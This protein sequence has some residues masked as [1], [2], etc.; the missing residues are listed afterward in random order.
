MQVSLCS[1]GYSTLA[2]TPSEAGSKAFVSRNDLC[3]ACW[4]LHGRT[5]KLCYVRARD[6]GFFRKPTRSR[7]SL[8]APVR[9]VFPNPR[10]RAEREHRQSA[11]QGRYFT[12]FG[13]EL[14]LVGV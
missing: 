7:L 3:C 1:Q 11:P 8:P 5:R 14:I 4:I 9:P 10:W 6:I 2:R 13:G 12:E